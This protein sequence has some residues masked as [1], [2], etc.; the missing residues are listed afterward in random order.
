M[1]GPSG[2]G[3]VDVR[4]FRILHGFSSQAKML[5]IVQ[6]PHCPADVLSQKVKS[7]F[8]M[9]TLRSRPGEP[10][11][12]LTSTGAP[13]AQLFVSEETVTCPVPTPFVTCVNT[14][15]TVPLGAL[16]DEQLAQR[17]KSG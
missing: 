10:A 9:S 11:V 3:K 1:S 14:K 8:P 2:T 13:T 17:L 15:T 5:R 16:A 12:S 6:A 7:V 4:E